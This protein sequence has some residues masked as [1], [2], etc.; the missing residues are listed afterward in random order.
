[1]PPKRDQRLIQSEHAIIEAGIK[2]FLLN[3]AAGMSEIAQ[4]SG[5]GRTTLYRHFDSKEAL[6]QAIALRCLEEINEA[7]QPVYEL[8]GRKAIEATF[9][10]L[11]PV[12]NRYRFLTSLWSEAIDDPQ[13]MQMVEQSAKDMEWLFNQAKDAGEIDHA[14]PNFW[15][16]NFYDMTLTTAW[17]LLESGDISTEK[18]VRFATQ[19]F[20]Q[21]CEK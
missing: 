12:A 4:I 2:T 13:V 3:P 15:L 1:M 14:L 16:T 7:L 11:M 21:G 6:V 19:S 9:E 8:S 17:S 5:V 10:L 18:A 20:F